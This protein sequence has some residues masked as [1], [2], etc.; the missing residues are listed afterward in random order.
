[1]TTL[2][3]QVC[4]ICGENIGKTVDGEPFIACDACAFP[5]CRLCYE[6]ERKDGKQSCL[7]CKT[8]YKK[9]KGKRN[10]KCFSLI[11]IY[12]LVCQCKKFY[13]VS[14][15]HTMVFVILEV[16]VIKTFLTI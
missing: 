4:K 8:R 13:A 5:V 14:K 11:L 7:Q 3:D 16:V 12:T 15:S 10:L 9:H 2:G 1:M 6:Y